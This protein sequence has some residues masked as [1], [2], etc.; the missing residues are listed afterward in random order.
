MKKCSSRRP[1]RRPHAWN[2]PEDGALSGF[3]IALLAWGLTT[4]ISQGTGSA[5]GPLFFY[6]LTWCA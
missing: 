5:A 4:M 3:F 1:R 2:R 6:S